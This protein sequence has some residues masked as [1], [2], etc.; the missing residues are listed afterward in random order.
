[1]AW[2]FGDGSPGVTGTLTPNHIFSNHGVYTV[3]LTVTDSHG[4][5]A[6]D[7]LI[8]TVLSASGLIKENVQNLT[9]FAGESKQLADVVKILTA[10]LGSSAWTDETH[11]AASAGDK[12][13]QDV[14]KA[15]LELEKLLKDEAKKDSVSTAAE[16]AIG[17][18][19][20]DIAAIAQVVAET[21][22]L[23]NQHLQANDP[24]KQKFVDGSLADA[25]KELNA[26]I[27]S[28]NA[29]DYTGAIQSFQR[30]WNSTQSALKSPG[31]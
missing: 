22:Y 21:L 13:F 26:G 2:D 31:K 17:Q 24:Q 23:E 9:P 11:L 29:G 19:V 27:A 5:S 6:S 4:A 14:Q 7:A 15:A 3:T 20:A 25:A 30:A 8:V 28:L 12:V 1:V 16:K 10:I 18:A